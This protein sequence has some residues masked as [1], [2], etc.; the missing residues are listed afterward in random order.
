[1]RR[2]LLILISLQLAQCSCPTGFQLERDGECRGNY[3]RI[4]TIYNHASRDVIAKCNEIDG[5]PIIIHDDDHQNYWKTHVEGVGA[6]TVI[7]LVCNTISNRWI[8]ADGS[9][10]DYIPLPGFYNGELQKNCMP[11]QFWAIRSDG[12]WTYFETENTA[13]TTDVFCTT[14]LL[15]PLP[16]GEDCDDF[17][18]DDQDG[19]CYQVDAVSKTLLDAQTMCQSLGANLASVHNSQENAFLRRLAVS[20]GAVNGVFLGATFSQSKNDFEW[21]DGSFWDYD[22]FYPE[23]PQ[24]GYGDCIG[25]DTSVSTGQWMNVECSMQLSVACEKRSLPPPISCNSGPYQD[26]GNITSPGYP[27]SA[28]T[29]CDFILTVE[30]GKKVEVNVTV[31]A[32]S[33]CDLLVLYDGGRDGGR[34]A[35]ILTGELFNATF[36]AKSNVMTVSWQPHGGVNVQGMELTFRGV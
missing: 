32:N 25:M 34:I 24:S 26:S 21:I 22:N 7:G 3:T 2:L 8:W 19:V 1:M 36:Y 4:S 17:E 18:S 30:Q 29:P 28:S 6:W 27:Y 12:Y 15:Q 5:L 23:Y 35:A 20:K 13:Y 9:P 31:E 11:K 16:V 33:C 14:Q 10:L